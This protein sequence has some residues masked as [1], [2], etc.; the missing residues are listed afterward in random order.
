M[1][2]PASWDR[3]NC[4][5]M[6]KNSWKTFVDLF[7]VKVAK[8][9]YMSFAQIWCKVSKKILKIGPQINMFWLWLTLK[10][11]IILS[12]ILSLKS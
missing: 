1:P 3:P 8:T 6:R 12:T 11:E 2:L 4:K 5:T 10:L 9:I 7:S